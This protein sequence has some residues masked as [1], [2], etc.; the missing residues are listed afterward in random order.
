MGRGND[1]PNSSRYYMR[2]INRSLNNMGRKAARP[3]GVRTTCTQKNL[4]PIEVRIKW[5]EEKQTT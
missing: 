4:S 3:E 2:K 1:K 5:A